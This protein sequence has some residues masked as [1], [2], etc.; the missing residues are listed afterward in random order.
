VRERMTVVER[1]LFEIEKR[2]LMPP[3]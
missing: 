1:R 3:Q 2:V